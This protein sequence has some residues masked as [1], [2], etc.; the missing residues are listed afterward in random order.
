MRP[1]KSVREAN[2]AAGLSACGLGLEGFIPTPPRRESEVSGF[3]EPSGESS[4]SFR[5]GSCPVVFSAEKGSTVT[6]GFSPDVPSMVEG[7]R[8]ASIAALDDEFDSG[9][10]DVDEFVRGALFCGARDLAYSQ[11]ACGLPFEGSPSILNGE[12]AHVES[13]SMV[14]AQFGSAVDKQQG[15]RYGVEHCAQTA[16]AVLRVAKNYSSQIEE[17]H[18]LAA[19]R[20]WLPLGHDDQRFISAVSR[21]VANVVNALALGFTLT[22]AGVRS[23]VFPGPARDRPPD[24]PGGYGTPPWFP[25]LPLSLQEDLRSLWGPIPATPAGFTRWYTNEGAQALNRLGF[26]WHQPSEDHLSWDTDWEEVFTSGVARWADFRPFLER[27]FRTRSSRFPGSTGSL[28]QF[29]RFT[30]TGG[31]CRA[32]MYA[33]ASDE[34]ISLALA[35][36]PKAEFSGTRVLR[37]VKASQP[38]WAAARRF[39]QLDRLGRSPRQ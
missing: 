33:A 34:A 29:S 9:K 11:V 25:I 13:I 37:R 27:Y 26:T 21:S 18:Y 1:P 19:S 12:V 10:P 7:A 16:H 8:L 39:V 30:S 31:I 14:T 6:L 36:P 24:E 4:F 35:F 15:V 38:V 20:S 5:P 23:T 2:K 17:D 3:S 28:A 32:S 22:P